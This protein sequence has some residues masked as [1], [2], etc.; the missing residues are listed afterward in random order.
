ME[1]KP[2]TYTVPTSN[3]Q[4]R[5][6]TV[7]QA[8]LEHNINAHSTKNRTQSLPLT[9]KAGNIT[10]QKMVVLSEA[11]YR[12]LTSELNAK[13]ERV[14]LLENICRTEI[15]TIKVELKRQDILRK[16]ELAEKSAEVELLQAK[17]KYRELKA[18]KIETFINLIIRFITYF[19]AAATSAATGSIVAV[20]L[21][22]VLAFI[23][24][25]SVV[26]WIEHDLMGLSWKESLGKALISGLITAA[27]ALLVYASVSLE[28]VNKWLG[29]LLRLI[30]L[31]M[32]TIPFQFQMFK[33][34]CQINTTEKI[35]TQKQENYTKIHNQTLRYSKQLK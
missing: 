13:S 29:L 8:I 9:A 17:E 18:Q 3:F 26:L 1:S 20:V 15:S 30:V 33:I 5:S 16:T 7:N 32:W 28:G 6:S 23:I 35:L 10:H 2:L 19:S 14:Q 34:W 22:A 31:Y 27:C 24:N 12:A 25:A 21:I 11:E 4:H